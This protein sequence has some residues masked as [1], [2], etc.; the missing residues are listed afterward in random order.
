M[1]LIKTI[2]EKIA[3]SI[4][5]QLPKKGT[6]QLENFARIQLP[7]EVLFGREVGLTMMPLAV[8]LR[9]LNSPKSEMNTL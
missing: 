6:G 7:Y 1:N 3:W 9:T 4:A 5:Y 8:V 2:N